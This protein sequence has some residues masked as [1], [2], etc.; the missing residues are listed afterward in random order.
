VGGGGARGR[1][2]R[3]G[4]AGLTPATPAGRRPRTAARPPGAPTP[5]A[6]WQ[7][8]VSQVEIGYR[9]GQLVR[10]GTYGSGV[11]VRVE[12]SGDDLQVTVEFEGGERKHLLPRYAPLIPLD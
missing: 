10:H 6:A 2:G 5:A 9:P 7:D 12:G 8:D 11:V 4:R 3:A 1:S